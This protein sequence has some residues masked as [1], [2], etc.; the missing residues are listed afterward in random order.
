MF[1]L[2]PNPFRRQVAAGWTSYCFHV[3]FHFISHKSQLY[4][5]LI[6]HLALPG[7]SGIYPFWWWNICYSDVSLH[8]YYTSSTNS[9]LPSQIIL[10]VQETRLSRWKIWSLL[11]RLSSS[12]CTTQ[13]NILDFHTV[14]WQYYPSA[15]LS[16]SKEC[17]YQYP[18]RCRRGL[19]VTV[20][21]TYFFH[22]LI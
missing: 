4:W 10:K 17:L 22:L 6:L 19:G 12:S 16:G 9:S 11:L 20:C 3:A 21:L 7:T 5:G 8:Y 2:P 13:I 15:T 18:D 14:L 1:C